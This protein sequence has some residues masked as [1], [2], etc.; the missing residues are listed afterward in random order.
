M[1]AVLQT[2]IKVSFHGATVAALGIM[3]RGV[4]L[5]YSELLPADLVAFI[6]PSI[7]ANLEKWL[8]LWAPQ[9]HSDSLVVLSLLP[10]E[11][12]AA[13]SIQSA[14]YPILSPQPAPPGKHRCHLP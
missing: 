10:R 8:K 2:Y 1:V 11:G 14:T 5:I 13:R 9:E 12:Q 4:R 6:I 3:T 7:L